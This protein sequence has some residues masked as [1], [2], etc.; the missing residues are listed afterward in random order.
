MGYEIDYLM[1]GDGKK[2][3][4]AICLRYGNL[5]GPRNEQTVI[6]IDGGTAESGKNLAQHVK[7]FYHTDIVDIALLTHPDAD[8]ASGM[9]MVLEE[10][11]V[12]Q[13]VMHLP[14]NH[15]S[16]VKALLEDTRSTTNSIREKTK[17]NLSVAREVEQLAKRKGIAIFEPFAGSGNQN[18]LRFLGPT[19]EFYEEQLACFDFM[20]GA[21]TEAL[22]RSYAELARAIGERILSWLSETWFA[23]NLKDPKDGASSPENNSSAILLL[24]V[25]GRKL[26]FTGD[27]GVPALT[28]AAGYAD[29]AGISLSGL[30]FFDVPHH[31]SK[32]NLGPTILNR[33]LGA[34]RPENAR[35]WTAYVSAAKEGAPK[36]PHKKVTN[37]LKR[38]GGDVHATAG[39]SVWH[40]HNAPARDNYHAL[41]PLPL[42]AQVE[43][44][45]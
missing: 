23:E 37:A 15:S 13:V 29:S 1:V 4:D 6:T 11:K 10:L 45:D 28:A 26:L 19:E 3:G 25:D 40:Q 16:D 43:N 27:A 32:R 18:G 22:N 44:D 30:S 21:E 39:K 5:F 42:Y 8:H 35:E 33:L 36:H 24:E 31:G 7:D 17:R 9:R 12:N 2:S 34:I 38:R 41:E 20:P 14:W